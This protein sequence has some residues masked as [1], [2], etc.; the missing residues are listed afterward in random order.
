MAFRALKQTGCCIVENVGQ[1]AGV[2]PGF[3]MHCG[4]QFC[5]HAA[6]IECQ[7]EDGSSHLLPCYKIVRCLPDQDVVSVNT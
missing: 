6:H 7:D 5:R 2:S 1:F 3:K 4:C